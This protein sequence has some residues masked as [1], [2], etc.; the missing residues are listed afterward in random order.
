MRC[1]ISHISTLDESALRWLLRAL[2]KNAS[3]F[4]MKLT[5]WLHEP[6]VSPA[7]EDGYI[8]LVI[9]HGEAIGWARTEMWADPAD[10]RRWQT[11]EAFVVPDRRGSGVAR[12]A[13]AGLV[14]SGH[15][16]REEPVA[17]FAAAMFAVARRSGLV[18]FRFGRSGDKW[19]RE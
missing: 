17:V 18:P 16:D 6:G 2:T 12:F 10:G 11:L 19:R 5:A 15:L 8:A 7:A 14:A 3:D 13:T 4:Q 1:D 9:E